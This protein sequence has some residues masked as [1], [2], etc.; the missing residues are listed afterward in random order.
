MKKIHRI[1][2][3][4]R[5]YFTLYFCNL[6]P[7]FETEICVHNRSNEIFLLNRSNKTIMISSEKLAR[8][9]RNEVQ[10]IKV[11]EICRDKSNEIKKLQTQLAY[12]KKQAAKRNNEEP[13]EA[14]QTDL[15]KVKK[16]AE[17]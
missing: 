11:K 1:K 16:F 3:K 6:S 7:N 15:S 14:E 5:N 17:I 13:K 12:Y 2:H 9:L 8:L 10:L 4:R